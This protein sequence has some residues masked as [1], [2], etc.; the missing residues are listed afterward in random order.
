MAL[1]IIHCSRKCHIEHHTNNKKITS[2][3]NDQSK[4]SE[5]HSNKTSVTIIEIATLRSLET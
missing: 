4:K 5:R 3:Y 1:H 2:I